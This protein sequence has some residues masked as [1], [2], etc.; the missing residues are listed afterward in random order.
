MYRV[1]DETYAA[2][3]VSL[4]PNTGDL[5][6]SLFNSTSLSCNGGTTVVDSDVGSEG[7]VYASLFSMAL[8]EWPVWV[9]V[10]LMKGTTTQHVTPLSA[11]YPYL[12]NSALAL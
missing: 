1:A 3:L 10:D 12:L 9:S 7:V 6:P 4:D 5:G 8:D 2:S 11:D